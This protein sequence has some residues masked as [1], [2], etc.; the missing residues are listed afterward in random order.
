MRVIW[1]DSRYH[2]PEII[3]TVWIQVRIEGQG[4]LRN[5]KGRNYLFYGEP[6][7]S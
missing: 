5:E 7:K 1:I 4:E 6:D 2:N 3:E